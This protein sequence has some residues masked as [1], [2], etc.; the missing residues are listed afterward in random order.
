MVIMSSADAPLEM[1]V[2]AGKSSPRKPALEV[3]GTT[4]AVCFQV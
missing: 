4:T 2:H 3:T 1:S